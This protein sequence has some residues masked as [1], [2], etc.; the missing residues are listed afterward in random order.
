MHTGHW[1]GNPA[2]YTTVE[3][4]LEDVSNQMASSKLARFA[5]NSNA[6]KVGGSMRVV[7]PNSA[8]NSP[9]GSTGLG[10]RRTVM[11]DGAYRRRLALLDQQDSVPRGPLMYNDGLTGS[12]PRSRPVSWHPASHPASQQQCQ[13]T[14]SVASSDLRQPPAFEMP[15]YSGYASPDS[16]VSPVSMPFN[17]YGQPQPTPQEQTSSFQLTGYAAAPLQQHHQFQVQAQHALTP[18]GTENMDPTMYSHFDWNSLAADDFEDSSTAPPTPENFLPIQHPE[19]VFPAA[20]EIPYHPLSLSEPESDGEELIGMGLYDAPEAVK[21]PSSNPDLDYYR[22]LMR[23]GYLGTG[24][25]KL[26]AT[27]KGLKLEEKYVPPPSD[28]EDEEE[29][30]GEGEDDDEAPIESVGAPF[31]QGTCPPTQPHVT[32]PS[33][34]YGGSG[35]L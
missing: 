35:W 22:G 25:R 11:S 26:A 21:T 27:G 24:T 20:E 12:P 23:S 9:R 6:Q 16:S 7:K 28:D 29:Q 1:E 32:I 5:R 4:L 3:M 14:Y 2:G 18:L 31:S 19:P 10:R 13:S 8:S 33:Q 17:G 30:D 15:V 34:W